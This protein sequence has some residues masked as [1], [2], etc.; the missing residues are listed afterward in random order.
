MAFRFS[1]VPDMATLTRPKSKSVSEVADQSL[2]LPDIPTPFPI[3]EFHQIRSTGQSSHRVNPGMKGGTAPLINLEAVAEA[4]PN[5]PEAVIVRPP[6]LLTYLTMDDFFLTIA[7]NTSINR[8]YSTILFND[9][10]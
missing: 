6:P 10:Q 5:A 2:M 4:S 1:T 3:N 7:R 8:V 9:P